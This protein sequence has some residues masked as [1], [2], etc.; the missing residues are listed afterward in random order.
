MRHL[1]DSDPA[2]FQPANINWGLMARPHEV[3]AIRSRRERRL[4]HAEI[5]IE[6]SR[7]W[8]EALPRPR[9]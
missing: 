6:H 9:A 5:A 4:R 8:F 1:T 2:H 3:L 7:A